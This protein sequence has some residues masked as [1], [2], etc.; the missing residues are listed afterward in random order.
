M[1]NKHVILSMWDGEALID[2]HLLIH[3]DQGLGD[4]IQFIRYLPLIQKDH[5]SHVTVRC[6]EEL[7][8][9]VKDLHC[10]NK[11]ISDQEPLLHA[12]N[13]APLMSLPHIFTTNLDTIPNK[14]PY[15]KVT[16]SKTTKW[17]RIIASEKLKVGICWQG[18]SSYQKALIRTC[19]LEQFIK[20][21]AK[22]PDIQF[23]SLQ[24]D[25]DPKM[26]HKADRKQVIVDV[27]QELTNVSETSAAIKQL[28]LVI[29]IDTV[30]VHIAGALN[31][32]IWNLIEFAPDWRWFLN[33]DHSPWYP[34]M[35]LFRQPK[36]DDW[37]SVF[38]DIEKS[39]TA[40]FLPQS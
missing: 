21:V 23:Y 16:R 20:I 14:V 5:K 2:Q 17:K 24:K 6:R 30:I 10:V 33:R 18:T 19:G 25:I 4:S 9:L 39:L 34:S 38:K 12:D 26:L 1:V 22:H 35:K 31:I 8:P 36:V 29:S 37:D 15:I 27:S 3:C 13:H 11:I 40:Y 32:P 28:D 7:I